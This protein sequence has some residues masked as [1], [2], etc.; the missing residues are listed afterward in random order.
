MTP[1]HNRVKGPE[2]EAIFRVV[3]LSAGAFP[4]TERFLGNSTNGRA[5]RAIYPPLS[6]ASDYISRY[7]MWQWEDS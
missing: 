2:V 3:L 6:A 7:A 1:F 5:L 4:S